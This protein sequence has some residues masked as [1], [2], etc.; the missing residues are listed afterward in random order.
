MNAHAV[1]VSADVSD[2]LWVTC[3]LFFFEQYEQLKI[4]ERKNKFESSIITERCII[5]TQ[6]YHK[7]QSKQTFLLVTQ[8][9]IQHENL[10]SETLMMTR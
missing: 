2:F 3:N 1:N 7:K 9:L 6:I 4:R 5:E 8:S 10:S